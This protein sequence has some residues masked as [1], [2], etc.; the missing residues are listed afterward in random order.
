MLYSSPATIARLT[1]TNSVI[2]SIDMLFRDS[3][4]V[5]LMTTDASISSLSFAT[6]AS[7]Y[8]V[9]ERLN[10]HGST[11]VAIWDFDCRTA[12]GATLNRRDSKEKPIFSIYPFEKNDVL[13]TFGSDVLFLRPGSR[14][15]VKVRTNYK[16]TAITG[17][18]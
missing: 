4:F 6:S 13:A 3:S 8:A 14:G 18:R 17:T 7:P 10:L 1:D 11:E 16:I 5:L 15:R 2:E 12:L 9:G